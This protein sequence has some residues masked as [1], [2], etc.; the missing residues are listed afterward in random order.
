MKKSDPRIHQFAEQVAVSLKNTQ[1]IARAVATL[2]DTAKPKEER[3]QAIQALTPLK[4][5]EALYPLID[6]V[7]TDK[8]EELRRAAAVALGAYNA[9]VIAER[10]LPNWKTLPQTV[11]IDL[12]NSLKSHQTSARLLLDAVGKGTVPRTDLTDNTILAIR[13][14]NNRGLNDQIEKVW[15]RYR[16]TPQELDQLISKMRKDI[17]AKPGDAAKGKLVFEKNCM[18]CHKYEGRGHEV[19]PQLDGADRSLDYLLG[20]ILDPNRVI[21]QPYYQRVVLL[22]SGQIKTGLLHGEDDSSI[23]LKGEQAAL[24]V[25]QKKDIDDTKIVEKSL[26][27]EGLDK[28]LTPDDFRDLV[29]YL[30]RKK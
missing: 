7:S 28:N 16:Q 3:Q 1:A 23:T 26:M 2:R 13:A 5:P 20:N 25:I 27:P 12:V 10:L 19:G 29:R 11:R 15:G 17:L 30:E 22:K 18:Q 14:F 4:P 21:G 8:D 6:L 24:D 9:P